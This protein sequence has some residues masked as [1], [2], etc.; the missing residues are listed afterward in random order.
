MILP[1]GNT[2]RTPSSTHTI[3]NKQEMLGWKANVSFLLFQVSIG[4]HCA[5]RPL[6][7]DE[8]ACFESLKGSTVTRHR[9]S[10]DEKN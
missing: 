4:S 5:F 2:Q 3:R 9:L 6:P 8:K 10:T 1:A 7:H